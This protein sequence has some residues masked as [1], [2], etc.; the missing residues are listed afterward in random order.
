M[1][2]NTLDLDS[3]IQIWGLMDD[4]VCT[5]KGPDTI[6][7]WKREGTPIGIP[8]DDLSTNRYHYREAFDRDSPERVLSLFVKLMAE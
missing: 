5:I 3:F 6:A 2:L 1:F 7:K 4:L 8:Y